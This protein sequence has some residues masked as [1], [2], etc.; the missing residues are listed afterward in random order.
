MVM[1]TGVLALSLTTAPK[2]E[3]GARCGSSSPT[4]IQEQC[5]R[6]TNGHAQN[7]RHPE[8]SGHGF[9]SGAIDWLATLA[10]SFWLA[11]LAAVFMA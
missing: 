1:R 11:V 2:Q 8:S 6:E 3:S 4:A 5:D 7:E 9:T 10:V